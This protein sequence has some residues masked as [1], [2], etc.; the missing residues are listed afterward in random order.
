VQYQIENV[1]YI[2]TCK[3]DAQRVFQE[4]REWVLN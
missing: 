1:A 2:G 4:C 3:E